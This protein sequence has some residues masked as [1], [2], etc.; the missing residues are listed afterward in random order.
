M[1]CFKVYA[2]LDQPLPYMHVVEIFNQRV[3]FITSLFEK[4]KEE[5]VCCTTKDDGNDGHQEKKRKQDK[6]YFS[7]KLYLFR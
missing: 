7:I 2:L 4:Q 5:V 3:P 1:M 6:K